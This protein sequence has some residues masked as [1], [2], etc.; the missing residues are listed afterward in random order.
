MP[1][2]EL[3]KQVNDLE[4]LVK[5]FEQQSAARG[6]MADSLGDFLED[7]VLAI[8]A[9]IAAPWPFRLIGYL[10]LGHQLRNSVRYFPGRSF[11]E[12]RT[13]AITTQWLSAE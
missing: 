4:L 11:Q 1:E 10:R 13:Q 2:S 8:E 12:R 9:V 3:A 5:R 7:R 6:R